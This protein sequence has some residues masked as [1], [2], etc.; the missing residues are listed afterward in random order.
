[1]VYSRVLREVCTNVR[2]PMKPIEKDELY[3]NLSQF[4]AAKGISL[5]EG[6]YSQ[7]IQKSCRIL[8]DVINLGQQGIERAKNG[9][10]QKLDQV[11]QIIHK[12]TP[13]KPPMGSKTDPSAG[14]SPA[15]NSQT[16]KAPE[17]KASQQNKSSKAGKRASRKQT[18]S[19]KRKP[20]R[21]S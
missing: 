16:D 12:K 13:P 4:L 19:A 18:P 8:A 17:P 20:R 2:L 15:G 9:I 10:D 5:K 21:S 11:R 6:S 1:I 7:T 14:Q 3:E